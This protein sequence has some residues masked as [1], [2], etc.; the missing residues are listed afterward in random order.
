MSSVIRVCSA[1]V[2]L[3]RAACHPTSKHSPSQEVKQDTLALITLP[4]EDGIDTAVGALV[5]LKS[6]KGLDEV[7]LN[8]RLVSDVNE[9]EV[10]V[11]HPSYSD[12]VFPD[13]ACGVPGNKGYSLQQF[14]LIGDTMLILPLIG[15]SNRLHVHVINLKSGQAFGN[16]IR[17]WFSI[18]WVNP[19]TACFV[20]ANTPRENDDGSLIYRLCLWQIKQ[21]GIHLLREKDVTTKDF[22]DYDQKAQY[23]LVKPLLR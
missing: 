6:R 15:V 3:T 19:K 8:Y 1:I 4:I 20:T 22:I 16:D 13:T 10:L 18:L 7:M 12:I 2:T 9:R 14:T 17:T 11:Y 23:D 21:D 5:Y